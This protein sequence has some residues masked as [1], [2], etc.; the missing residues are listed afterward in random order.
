MRITVLIKTDSDKKQTTVQQPHCVI[1][2]QDCDL[3]IED[4]HC[5]RNHAIL[6]EGRGGRLKVKDLGS[7][8]GTL[9]KGKKIQDE[10]IEVG[11]EIQ[12]GNTFLKIVKYDPTG[13]VEEGDS[14]TYV[15]Q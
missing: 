12:I 7:F 6:Y 8:N 4:K 5:S 2:R 15:G 10:F 9:I 13:D 14:D 3:V 11:D 1:G